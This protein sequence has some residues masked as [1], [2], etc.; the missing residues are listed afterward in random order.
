MTN[1]LSLCKLGLKKVEEHNR[2]RFI[3]E[4]L[5]GLKSVDT[6]SLQ[7]EKSLH[8]LYKSLQVISKATTQDKIN[9][10]KSLTINSILEQNS[11]T[12]E[13]YE[14]YIRITDE[15]TDS[16]FIYLYKLTKGI[17][18]DINEYDK[19]RTL[20]NN[21]KDDLKNELGFSDDKILCIRNSLVG[22]GLLDYVLTY[23]GNEI[24]RITDTAY[25]YIK[26]VEGNVNN[27]YE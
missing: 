3:Q 26:Y 21:I 16:E 18:K 20:Y 10:F 22:R 24:G 11:L 25:S 17:S 23:G 15:L 8:R 1:P 27:D 4:V 14:L 13:D 9:R 19:F 2:D 6:E 5:T 12:D 7:A